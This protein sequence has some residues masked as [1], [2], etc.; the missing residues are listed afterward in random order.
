MARERISN[1]SRRDLEKFTEE[2]GVEVNS[3]RGLFSLLET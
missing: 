2:C 1:P 3:E